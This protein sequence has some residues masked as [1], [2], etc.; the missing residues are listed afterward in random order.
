MVGEKWRG[1]EGRG[2]P[3]QPLSDDEPKT[4]CPRPPT[5]WSALA[6]QCEDLADDTV[7]VG[8]EAC[9]PVATTHGGGAA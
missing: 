7:L 4:T 1:V 2:S 5:P 3:S 9:S 8:G 6:P